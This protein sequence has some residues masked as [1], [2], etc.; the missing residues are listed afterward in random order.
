MKANGRFDKVVAKFPEL[1]EGLQSA[2][3]LSRDALREI[4]ERGIYVF[5]DQYGEPI[6]IGRSDRMRA[7][8]LEHSRPSS[9]HNSATFAFNLAVEEAKN[10][11]LT[12]P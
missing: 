12:F 7:R 6:Y 4:P 10:K 9:T 3:S 11:G 5:H 8:L 2:P 1:L